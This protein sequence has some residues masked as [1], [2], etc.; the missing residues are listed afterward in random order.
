MHFICEDHMPKAFQSKFSFLSYAWINTVSINY[1]T[2]CSVTTPSRKQL[3][4]RGAL[5]SSFKLAFPGPPLCNICM[6]MSFSPSLLCE[7]EMLSQYHYQME[8]SKNCLVCVCPITQPQH[9]AC[10]FSAVVLTVAREVILL[11]MG[12]ATKTIK[13]TLSVFNTLWAVSKYINHF[14]VHI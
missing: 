11:K 5:L 3:C 8:F 6:Y 13:F 14:Y 1:I 10:F 4:R 7:H 12:C 2:V 9:Y